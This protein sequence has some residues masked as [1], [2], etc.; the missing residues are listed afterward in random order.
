MAVI[1]V[2]GDVRQRGPDREPMPE[3][4]MTYGQHGFNGT[5]LSVV[6]QTVGDP[7][8]LAATLRQVARKTATD[9]AMKF[10]TMEEILSEKR[11]RASISDAV[12]RG[13][14]RS[15]GVSGH[16]R[17]LWS[18]DLRGRPALKRHRH[19]DRIGREVPAPRF[20]WYSCR[21]WRS[22]VSV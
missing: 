5:T 9:V 2:A 3:C 19:T 14:R 16:G 8:A 6:V 12:V 15:G 20:G 4:Y 17:G 13:L 1:V 10:T 21:G 7:N 22:Q 11:C 18:E